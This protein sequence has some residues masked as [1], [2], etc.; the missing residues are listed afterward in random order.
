MVEQF[1][2]EVQTVIFEVP[3]AIPFR[4]REFPET[5]AVTKFELELSKRFNVAFDGTP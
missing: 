1:P 5:F 3:A 2:S 4:F